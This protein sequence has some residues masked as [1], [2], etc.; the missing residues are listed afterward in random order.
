[1]WKINDLKIE[2]DIEDLETAEK[3]DNALIELQK[4]EKIFQRTFRQ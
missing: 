3:L 4:A 1:M 2:F